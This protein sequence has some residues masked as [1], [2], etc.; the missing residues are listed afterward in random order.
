[1]RRWQH[2]GAYTR[3]GICIPVVLCV[4]LPAARAQEPAYKGFQLRTAAASV[5]DSAQLKKQIAAAQTLIS[6]DIDSTMR[7]LYHVLEQ[8]VKIGYQYGI[9][10]A[11]FG[12]GYASYKKGEYQ[13]AMSLVRQSIAY[14][15]GGRFPVKVNNA[16]GTFYQAMGHND[17]ALYYYYKGLEQ[18]QADPDPAGS[19]LL[20][21]VIC[22]NIM[23]IYNSLEISDANT[24]AYVHHIDSLLSGKRDPN[25]RL[26]VF[27]IKGSLAYH[28][29]VFD[30][31]IYYYEK[32]LALLENEDGLN[33]KP[34]V[35]ANLGMAYVLHG[36]YERGIYYLNRSIRSLYSRNDIINRIQAYVF[37]SYA[38]FRQKK[39][40]EA[41]ALLE[42]LTDTLRKTG[43]YNKTT[44]DIYTQLS[45]LYTA[46][47]NYAKALTAYK[48]AVSIHDSLAGRNKVQTVIRLESEKAV[49]EKDRE[50][51][52]RKLQLAEKDNLL[53]EKN[54]WLMGISTGALLL[55][56]FIIA[57][58]RNSRHKQAVLKQKQETE[59]LKATMRGE[60]KE[61]SR[62]SRELHD[63]IGSMLASIRLQLGTL[64][65]GHADRQIARNFDNIM[66]LLQE[67]SDEVRKTAH[68]LMPDI[69]ARNNL[70][71]VLSIYCDQ[72][73]K[74]HKIETVLHF[75][76]ALEQ[77]DKATELLLYRICQELIQNIIKHANASL[78]EI[79]VQLD[80]NMLTLMVEDNGGGFDPAAQYTGSGLQNLHY[81]VNALQGQLVIN[82]AKGK[83]TTIH[84]AFDLNKLTGSDL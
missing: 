49:A 72:I 33:F 2:I 12:L 84:I 27:L 54:I 60:E 40:T 70:T 48:T 10:N 68:N 35:W 7:L 17:S 57:L 71:E 22:H 21:S 63:G 73:N 23:V 62:L 43:L 53:K 82:S 19:A 69:L 34:V 79:Q 80:E 9:G 52:Q 81:R 16:L 13:N 76:G 28:K 14:R 5:P 65:D 59:Q 78:A 1:M 42:P 45:D 20:T 39:Y 55:G 26:F 37:L 36:Q 46:T 18:L 77:L 11:L 25:T 51:T 6:T 15:V 8:S 50:I 64:R 61:R 47:G 56:S 83:H 38:Y 30:S 32:G 29:Q 75:H 66:Q 67:T 41:I 3:S 44:Y 24:P 4:L 58:Y 31:A 74:S